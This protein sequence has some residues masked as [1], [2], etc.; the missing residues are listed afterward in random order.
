MDD[1]GFLTIKG[2]VEGNGISRY[3]W[4]HEITPD[5]ARELLRLCEPFPV[6]KTRYLIPF[7]GHIFEVDVFHG[8]NEGLVMAELELDNTDEMFERPLWL[9]EEVSFDR[10]YFNSYL[11][12]KPFKSW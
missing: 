11:S 4:E 12:K 3:E 10:R 9:G 1:Q 8:E 6:I 7:M 5:D 2:G